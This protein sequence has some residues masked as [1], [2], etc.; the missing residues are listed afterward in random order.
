MKPWTTSSVRNPLNVFR[1]MSSNG[2]YVLQRPRTKARR[3]CELI[4]YRPSGPVG[5]EVKRR[6][7]L[8]LHSLPALL[9]SVVFASARFAQ[10]SMPTTS[11]IAAFRSTFR[12]LK[13]PRP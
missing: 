12:L 9:F 10:E 8:E 7:A 2:N 4:P 5:G 11:G 13:N 6:F 1:G 3:K